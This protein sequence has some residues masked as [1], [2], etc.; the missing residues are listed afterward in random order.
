LQC[1]FCL[2]SLADFRC[3]MRTVLSVMA[4]VRVGLVSG[5]QGARRGES[6]IRGTL[7]LL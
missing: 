3:R 2:S 1:N 4:I 6:M 7:G 5:M